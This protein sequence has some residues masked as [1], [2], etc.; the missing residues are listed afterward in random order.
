M[1]MHNCL[2]MVSSI[3]P[4]A[5]SLE[6]ISSNRNAMAL[7]VIGVA[8]KIAALKTHWFRPS[9]CLKTTLLELPAWV[10]NVELGE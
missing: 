1:P 6:T 7:M 10:R 9:V 4:R 2:P 5:D 8:S 3:R